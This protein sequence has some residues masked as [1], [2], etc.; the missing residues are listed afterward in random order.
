M[1]LGENLGDRI[2]IEFTNNTKEDVS[3][4]YERRNKQLTT[5]GC[6]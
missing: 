3:E 2:V 5:I 1:K 6:N 4:T